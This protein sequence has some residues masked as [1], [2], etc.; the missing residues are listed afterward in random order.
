MKT[1]KRVAHLASFCGNIGDQLNHQT[2]QSW[3]QTL[4]VGKLEWNRF[5]IRDCYRR[6]TKFNPDFIQ[7]AK[8]NE[9][10]VIGGGNFFELW[11]NDSENG[12]SIDLSIQEIHDIDRPIIF[13][14][15]GVDTAQGISKNA[16]NNF[17]TFFEHL[18]NNPKCF[19]SVRN[20][21]SFNQLL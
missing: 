8:T 1:S 21:G 16:K 20:D 2:F 6:K 7:F 15:I 18:T 5:E 4:F 11:P 14:A 13:N 9:I 3:F 12:T 17:K 10:V 19:V